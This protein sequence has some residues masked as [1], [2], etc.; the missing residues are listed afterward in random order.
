MVIDFVSSFFK[1]HVAHF[2]QIDIGLNY[3]MLVFL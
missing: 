2:R 1:N 3:L